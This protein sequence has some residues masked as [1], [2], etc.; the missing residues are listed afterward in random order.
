M[1]CGAST[2]HCGGGLLQVPQSQNHP[3][4]KKKKEEKLPAPYSY[5]NVCIMNIMA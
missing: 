5:C 3:G 2:A 4:T 1:G